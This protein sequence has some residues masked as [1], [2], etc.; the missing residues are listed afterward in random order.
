MEGSVLSDH[1]F[2]LKLIATLFGQGHANEPAA[3]DG[4]EI[5]LIGCYQL[6]SGNKV[7]FIFTILIID[8]NDKFTVPDGFDCFGYGI[9]LEI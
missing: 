1:H 2:E 5:D 3:M 9:E 7:T 8:H 6:R 4:H